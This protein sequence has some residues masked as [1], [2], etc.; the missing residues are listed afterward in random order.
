LAA[1]GHR[2]TPCGAGTCVVA[3][4]MPTVWLPYGI[5]CKL[6]LKRMAEILDA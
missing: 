4:E 3:F 6:A 1:T 5:V 2:L